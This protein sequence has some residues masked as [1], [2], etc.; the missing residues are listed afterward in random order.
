MEL[1]P[2]QIEAIQQ[3]ALE[4]YPV[5]ERPKHL[6]AWDENSYERKVALDFTKYLFFDAILLDKL[7]LQSKDEWIEIKEGCRMPEN[8]QTV[9]LR[10]RNDIC[11]GFF[12][13]E[14]WY[15]SFTEEEIEATH[16][17]YIPEV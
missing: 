10:N 3:K 6:S 17:M 7:N 14:H 12:E 4:L 15:D 9:L 16:W 11:T 1:T 5:K 13:S 2:E 8:N